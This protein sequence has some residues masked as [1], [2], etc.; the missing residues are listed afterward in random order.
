MV[1]MVLQ[2]FQC[3]KDHEPKKDHESFA[4]CWDNAWLTSPSLRRCGRCVGKPT[5]LMDIF[6]VLL[7]QSLRTHSTEFLHSALTSVFDNYVRCAVIVCFKICI[8]YIYICNIKVKMDRKVSFQ[9]SSKFNVVF[10][11]ALR[12]NEALVANF[13][14][15]RRRADIYYAW[16][17]SKNGRD[18]LQIFFLRKPN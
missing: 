8:I 1:S 12:R 9:G 13:W 16:S 10:R 4:Q 7:P 3:W 2:E 17:P 15:L 6:C 11:Q 14:E 18:H 5:E